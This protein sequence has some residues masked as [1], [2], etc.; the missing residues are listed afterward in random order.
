MK[1]EISFSLVSLL[2]V[3][4]IASSIA[5]FGDNKEPIYVDANTE[6]NRSVVDISEHSITLSNDWVC[7]ANTN[8]FSDSIS[9][10]Q[11]DEGGT[12]SN[13]DAIHGI[14]RIEVVLD[15]GL[16]ALSSGLALPTGEV[17]Y[18]RVRAA[19]P[20]IDYTFNTYHPD[21]FQLEFTS[22]S[23]VRSISISYSSIC[24]SD[25][26]DIGICFSPIWASGTTDDDVDLYMVSQSLFGDN[27]Y[28]QIEYDNNNSRYY[29][30]LGNFPIGIYPYELYALQK[31]DIM[32]SIRKCNEDDLRIVANHSGIYNSDGQFRPSWTEGN[33]EDPEGK[34][35]I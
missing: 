3:I 26:Y 9:L 24:A 33:N 28:H 19:S 25:S 22:T 17:E 29:I 12:L 31:G 15:S 11:F 34:D 35:D 2:L 4:G 7:S 32:S 20:N 5:L 14:R 10:G 30:F 8:G 1:K 6:I 18:T 21:Y 16:V 27:E 23:V 13:I